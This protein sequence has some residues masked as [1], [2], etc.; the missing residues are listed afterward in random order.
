MNGF[1]VIGFRDNDVDEIFKVLSAVIL[2]GELNFT[3]A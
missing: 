3:Y 1:K 2:L